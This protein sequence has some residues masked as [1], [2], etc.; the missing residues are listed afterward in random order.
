MSVAL[1]CHCQ[2]HSICQKWVSVAFNL[3]FNRQWAAKL[4]KGSP[5]Y[6]EGELIYEQYPRKVE[7]KA[8]KKTVEVEIM[9]TVAKI[10]VSRLISLE[11]AAPGAPGEDNGEGDAQ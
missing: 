2:S 10:K 8:G 1:M 11:P 9:V 7:T 3:P 4:P 5:L 6:V